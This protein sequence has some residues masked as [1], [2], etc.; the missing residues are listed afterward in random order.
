MQTDPDREI[1]T[2]RHSWQSGNHTHLHTRH[3]HTHTQGQHCTVSHT[4][5]RTTQTNTHKTQH[6]Y[7]MHKHTWQHCTEASKE[8]TISFPPPSDGS[9]KICPCACETQR[10]RACVC[11]SQFVNTSVLTQKWCRF[12]L[13]LCIQKK[14]MWQGR[15]HNFEITRSAGW[16]GPLKPL[17]H[18]SILQKFS[19]TQEPWK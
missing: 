2:N 17:T 15:L 11:A 14:I 8:L 19:C 4:Q 5:T 12:L 10:A 7:R 9:D 1:E 3:T 18:R 6:T 16:G 13:R